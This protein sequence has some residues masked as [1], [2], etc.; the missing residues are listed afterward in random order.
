[1]AKDLLREEALKFHTEGRPGK[2]EIKATKPLTTQKELSLAYSPGVAVPCL[3]IAKNPLKVYNYT[4]KGNTVAI[5]SNGTA[6]LGLGNIGAL[7]S[8]PVM[9]GKAILFKRFADIDGIDIEVDTEDVEEFI[10]AVKHLG[11]SF[12]GINLED[13]K[14][15]ECFIIEDRLKEIMDIP[16]FHD[17]QHGTAIAVV[18]GLINALH[19]TNKK[20]EDVKIVLNG[21]GAASIACANLILTMGAKPENILM[22]DRYGV[23]YKGRNSNMNDRKKK[24]SV[25]T[26]ARTLKDATIS[27][28]VFIGLSVGKCLTKDMIANMAPLP[29]IFAMAN[30][31]PEA[32]PELVQEV[33]SDAIIA[34]GRSDY[35][36]QVNNA[37]CFPYIF[38]GALDVHATHINDEMKMAA[39]EAIARLGRE[40]VPEEANK[41]YAGKKLKYGVD[42]IIPVPF[43]PRLIQ[44]VP[45]AVARSAMD[46]GVARRPIADMTSY[47]RELK[48]LLDPTYANLEI[49]FEKVR[50][51]P[52]KVVFSEGEEEVSIRAAVHFHNQGLGDAIVIGRE[53]HVK[54]CMQS[55]NL[56]APKGLTIHNAKFSNHNKEYIDF[57]YSRLQRKGYLY[58]DCQRLVHQDR[59]I[60]SACML[61]FDHADAVVTGLTRNHSNVLDDILK[62]I[63]PQEGRCYFGLSIAV[64]NGR[65]V[66]LSDT[67]VH[68]A[69]DPE[70]LSKIAK[71]S[72]DQ[73]KFLGSRPRVAFFIFLKFWQSRQYTCTQN[74]RSRTH[75]GCRRCGL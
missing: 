45:P 47:A 35:P 34:T 41:A 15:P 64:L 75:I 9:E 14:A 18:A 30:P 13:I 33:R 20:V 5:I 3:E 10:N 62:V 60:F 61:Q 56:R 32:R 16:I 11:P 46:S 27:A 37:L 48:G 51:N 22:L 63:D 59:N 57:L 23:I 55:L 39:A 50:K 71:Q 72:A 69:P 6:V 52:R 2:L 73:V 65:S 54:E 17:D 8:K 68:A 67:S 49:I 4:T 42:Y 44:I 28:D 29:I 43:D 7:A 19:I 1:M 36:N 24:F 70:M 40:E 12:G 31:E 66:M 26:K 53:K 38:R 58:R 21:A 25:D 74:T